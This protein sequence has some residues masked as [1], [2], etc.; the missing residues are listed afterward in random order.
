MKFFA[1]LSVTA[2]TGSLTAITGSLLLGC[3]SEVN[4][5]EQ[6]QGDF[7]IEIQLGEDADCAYEGT[8]ENQ[9]TGEVTDM[10]CEVE[11]GECSCSG[12]TEF[13]VYRVTITDQK[14]SETQTTLIEVEA[15][16]P[17]VCVNRD[18][19]GPFMPVDGEGGAGGAGGASADEK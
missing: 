13:T 7:A 11:E 17:P 10:T 2:M 5:D 19:Q 18:A 9:E 12:G 3:S 15:A 1:F 16:P 4:C 14:T 8:L 6:R